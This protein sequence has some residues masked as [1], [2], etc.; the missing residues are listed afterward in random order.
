[1][2]KGKIDSKTISTAILDES[3]KLLIDNIEIAKRWKRYIKLLFKGK[4]L[5]KT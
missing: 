4:G 3:E 1:M 5:K 2:K